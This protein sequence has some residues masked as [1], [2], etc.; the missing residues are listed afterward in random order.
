MLQRLSFKNIGPS[1]EM[2]LEFGDRLN[3]LT[4]DNGLGKTFVLDAAWWA[5]TRTWA[6]GKPLEPPVRATETPVISYLIHGVAGPTLEM[7]C[8]Y[9]LENGSWRFKQGRKPIPGLVVYARVDGGF[10]V[11]DP[12]RNYWRQSDQSPEE[13]RQ[14]PSSFQFTRRQVW[15]GLWRSEEAE[16][17]RLTDDLLCRGLVEDLVTWWQQK[18]LERD[19]FQNLLAELSPRDP[20]VLSDPVPTGRGLVKV[21]TLMA[22]YSAEP[23]RITE[24][25]AGV[26]RIVSL[27]YMLMWSWL[28]HQEEVKAFPGRATP[29]KRLILLFDEIE[30]HL[31]PEWQ[32]RILPS[33]LKAVESRLLKD[34]GIPVQIIGTT[35]A[36]LVLA[37]MET[38]FD[39]KTDKLFNLEQNENR[40]IRVEEVK[41]AKFGDASGW[42]TSPAFDMDSGYSEAAE[43]AMKAADD[44]MAGY[45]EELPSTLATADAI[46]SELIRT[47]D[48]SDPYWGFWLPFYR[49][50]K[51][52][53]G[54]RSHDE[55]GNA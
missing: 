32:R 54:N 11:W 46:Q 25:S 18:G 51:P 13:D 48:T 21:P 50:G 36:P 35:H 41:W 47:L 53:L 27:A 15:S 29:A 19:L 1:P 42:L 38:Q 16:Q 26:R 10:S 45:M 55:G 33:L 3:L 9:D 28:T 6:D 4:G 34:A 12:A 8:E 14:R 43:R 2:A 52:A 22:S 31:H 20:L 30:T 40:Q 5:L 23:I 7:T 17:K 37:S 44:L 49:E 24:A 39:V